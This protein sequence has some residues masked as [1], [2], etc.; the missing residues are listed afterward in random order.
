[1]KIQI[2]PRGMTLTK[3]QRVRWERDLDLALARFGDRIDRVIVEISKGEGEQLKCCEIELRLKPT[4]LKVED[5]DTDI[6]LAIE[7][8]AQ[9]IARSVSRAIE[10]ERLVR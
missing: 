6:S 3:T 5:S 2:R 9:R 7:H 10:N 8:A 1:M 4:I